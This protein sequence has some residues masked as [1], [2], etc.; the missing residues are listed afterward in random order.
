MK[1][2]AALISYRRIECYEKKKTKSHKNM[3][4]C[5][6]PRRTHVG[7]LFNAYFM[8]SHDC[9]VLESWKNASN[10]RCTYLCIVWMHQLFIYYFVHWKQMS[11]TRRVV[12]HF[13]EC[14]HTHS[15]GGRSLGMGGMLR[16]WE[17]ALYCTTF[18]SNFL[19]YLITYF[20]SDSQIHIFSLA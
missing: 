9:V 7:R 20:S 18:H 10:T 17:I 3:F 16:E 13:V 1:I 4:V 6:S 19:F 11:C 5:P 12:S 15:V 2:F 14:V 8:D